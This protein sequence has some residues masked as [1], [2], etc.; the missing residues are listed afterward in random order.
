[1]TE[2]HTTDVVLIIYNHQTAN[3]LKSDSLYPSSLLNRAHL[4]F[5]SSRYLDMRCIDIMYVCTAQRKSHVTMCM[6]GQDEYNNNFLKERNVDYEH[7]TQKLNVFMYQF[8]AI[9]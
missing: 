4:L 1:M 5:N 3:G 6:F 9:F 7:L 8:S 2:Y